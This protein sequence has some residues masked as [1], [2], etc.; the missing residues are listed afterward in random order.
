[1][2]EID[3]LFEYPES[4]EGAAAD[5][6][7]EVPPPHE[8]PVPP[9]LAWLDARDERPVRLRS[10][11]GWLALQRAVALQPQAALAALE[12]AGGDPWQ[13][14]S[15]CASPRR[16]RATDLERS[17]ALL[18]DLQIKALPIYLL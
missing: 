2:L 11:S 15:L 13:A 7:R 18:A 16:S 5:A 3:P 10:L 8:G 1:M 17:R 9:H 12:R 14:L 4:V 6:S